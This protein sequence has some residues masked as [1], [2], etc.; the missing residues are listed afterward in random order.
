[1]KFIN[2]LKGL[3]SVL[4]R[5]YLTYKPATSL[6]AKLTL[7]EHA[8]SQAIT[9]S[10][11][12]KNNPRF[13]STTSM[14]VRS[15]IESLNLD[16]SVLDSTLDRV[17]IDLKQ[18]EHKKSPFKSINPAST[19]P[20]LHDPL[21]GKTII[22]SSQIVT[23]LL[24]ELHISKEQQ[25][26]LFSPYENT[27][28]N[29]ILDQI[30]H[31]TIANHNASNPTTLTDICT[32]SGLIITDQIRKEAS[33]KNIK[34]FM[35]TLEFQ[36][37]ELEKHNTD[38]EDILAKL[39]HSNAGI[40]A[41]AN[42][43]TA[44]R[45]NLNISKFPKTDEFFNLMNK[46]DFIQKALPENQPISII[47]PTN[48]IQTMLSNPDPNLDMKSFIS[49]DKDN[50]FPIQ[51]L[52]WGISSTQTDPT[53]Q[54][55][56]RIGNTVI[57]IK[58]CVENGH[59]NSLS[60]SVKQSL[61]KPSLN[62]FM[63][64][65]KTTWNLTRWVLQELLS[66]QTP[67]T[68]DEQAEI[69][70]PVE[71]TIMHMPCNIG[72]YTDFYASK[73]HATNV[74]TMFRGA[75]NALQPNWLAM[76]IGYHGRASTIVVGGSS[77]KKPTLITRPEGQ[78]NLGTL[79]PSKRL[80]YELEM[81][82]ILG[83]KLNQMGGSISVDA[84]NEH[85]FG[86]VTFNDLSARDIQKAEYVPLGPF[87]GKNFAS[88]ISPWIMHQDVVNIKKELKPVPT[89]LANYLRPESDKSIHHDISLTV[90]LIT[91]IDKTPIRIAESNMTHQS[92]SFEQMIA[93]HSVG[94]CKLN[95]GDLLASGTLSAKVGEN[96]AGI[97][98]S[99]MGSML[100]ATWGG[101]APLI[102]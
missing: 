56:T 50:D 2:S 42:L 40:R 74:G 6:T 83:G 87:N 61:L 64:F 82:V 4:S 91:E 60:D 89:E 20:T 25:K 29:T 95:P 75:D 68:K 100:E 43:M 71:A 10:D 7:Y 30:T 31:S 86:T 77:S 80:D 78:S 44:K 49:V 70:T 34:R 37:N 12:G 18:G 19:V 79:E 63:S 47:A 58:K 97:L 99:P 41:F 76:P 1:M 73:E 22:E 3:P 26:K 59:L 32:A 88:T 53:P 45:F 27:Y 72:D 33:T 23:E 15:I 51:N 28:L 84:A 62:D 57:S 35:S 101:K 90:D 92:Y 17:H 93:H 21:S 46:Q 8:T 69:C 39:V 66:D 14:Y 36:L 52:P 81:G 16:K 98:P 24:N 65:D 85:I 54:I 11:S 96:Y 13:G 9:Q 55:S 102:L 38:N 48:I 67:L 5:P 94:G